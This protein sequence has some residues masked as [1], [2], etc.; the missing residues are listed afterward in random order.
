[1]EFRVRLYQG[2]LTQQK[3]DVLVNAANEKLMP[4]GGVCGAVHRHGGPN[5]AEACRT[6]APCPT[7][8]AKA[9]SAG[10][11]PVKWV[12]HAVGPIW[13][14][15]ESQEAELLASAYRSALDEAARLG[16]QSIAFP[17]ISCG[18]YGF[19]LALAAR[20]ALQA[21]EQKAQTLPQM[22]EILMVLFDRE[23]F[24]EFQTQQQALCPD[25]L[26]LG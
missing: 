15:G 8:S 26:R 10:N 21:L 17:A 18:I 9:T 1:M 23:T 7:G 20:I 5:L 13:R 19:P 14:G 25:D 4:G 24:D 22:R 12:V 16:A 11:L 2:D 6:L 3:V